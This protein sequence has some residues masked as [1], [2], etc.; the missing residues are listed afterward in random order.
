M[1]WFLSTQG[2]SGVIEAH[3]VRVI[4]QFNKPQAREIPGEDVTLTGQNFWV[5]TSKV[6]ITEADSVKTGAYAALGETTTAG[7][8]IP[9][10]KIANGA[11]YVSD[12]DGS[13]IER[14]AWGLRSSLGY[15]FSP[16]GRLITTMNS[17]NPMPPR[18]LM[19]DWEPIYEVI[20]GEWYGWPDFY[21]GIPITNERFGVKK[22]NRKFVLTPETHRKLLKGKDKPIQP[23]AK[24][25][26]HAATQDWFLARE[27]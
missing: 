10:E 8:V 14:I 9:G 15:R 20:E 16:D 27:L 4:D 17:A 12:L 22:E 24:L 21:S 1:Y 11:F 13:N 7:Q 3:W 5:P 25:S 18:G 19:F 6:S 23:L 26:S 2:N